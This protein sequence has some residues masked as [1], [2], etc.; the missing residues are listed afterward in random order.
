MERIHEANRLILSKTEPYFT[1]AKEWLERYSLWMKDPAVAPKSFKNQLFKDNM[2]LIKEAMSRMDKAGMFHGFIAGLG[3]KQES[4]KYFEESSGK[5]ADTLEFFKDVGIRL[6][7]L[8]EIGIQRK[9][10]SL[11]HQAINDSEKSIVPDSIIELRKFVLD[12]LKEKYAKFSGKK[13]SKFPWNLV[14]KQFK[15]LNFPNLNLKKHKS[16]TKSMLNEI[17]GTIDN[18]ELAGL[19]PRI[20]NNISSSLPLNPLKDLNEFDRNEHLHSIFGN[21]LI[22][23]DHP[24]REKYVSY[25]SELNLTDGIFHIWLLK[26]LGQLEE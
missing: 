14:N 6:K 20:A 15:L 22:P 1:D 16:W 19:E 21:D 11:I 13:I 9:S 18:I 5:G 17:L 4:L 2:K 8:F 12:K 25:L 10:L 26:L 3:G 23:F 7:P 24:E